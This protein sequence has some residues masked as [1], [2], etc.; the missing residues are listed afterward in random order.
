MQVTFSLRKEKVDK[1]GL[2]PVLMTIS[3]N[4]IR[5]RKTVKGVK[6]LPKHWKTREQRVKPSLK[7]DVYNYHIEY[8]KVIDEKEDE[9]KK[10]FRYTL[11]N[12]INPT[13]DYFLEKL[14]NGLNKLNLTYEFFPSFEE[15]KDSC[16][17]TKTPRTIKSYVTTIN[18][19]K[20]FESF[21][22]T[23]LLFDSIDSTFFEKLQDYTFTE[24]KNKNSY[25]A[26][27]IKILK[28][29]MNWS[30]D[31]EYHNNLK[32]KKFK[33]KEDETEIIYLT[34]EELMT[35]YNHDFESDR[36]NQV[37][38]MYV[39]NSVTGL[40]ISDYKTLKQSNI[41][42]DYLLI[43]I[44][45]T[46]AIN[47]KI[48]LN[49][50]SREILERYKDTI[51]EPLPVISDQK[52]N[53]YIKECCEIVEINSLVTKTRYIGQKRVEITVPKHKLITSH[54]ARKTFVT[55]SLILGM[56]EMVVRNI[57][58]HKKEESFR[59]YVKIAEDFKRQE[60]GNT[61]DKV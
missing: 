50:F 12:N 44:Q 42:K 9:I 46:K 6:S 14:E 4:S 39:F 55:N 38:D 52:F 11:L 35:L 37:R 26:F 20:D 28:T 53:K 60:M 10:L 7:N 22:G 5:I 24:R 57:T 19:L 15:F 29:F 23:K 47:T 51:H 13:K 2:M 40:R 33:A 43:T 17:S 8:N 41:K 18:F 45:K 59:R 58:G 25:F 49:K 27:I 3:F 56:K 30:L 61:W 31:K 21:S 48:P 36:L 1:N 34:M 54:T 32:Y 16:K